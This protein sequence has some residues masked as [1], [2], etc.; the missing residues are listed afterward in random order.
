[1]ARRFKMVD[2]EKALDQTVTIRDVLPPD[3]LARFIARVVLLLDLSAIYAQYAP[4]GG[5]AYAPELLLGLLFY[6]YATGVFSSRKIEKATYESIPFRFLAG[7]WHPDHD[8]IA[9][10]RKTF[11]PEITNLF[12]QVL[13]IAHELGV[14]KLGTIS[15]DGS[16]VHADASKSHAV[17]YGRLLQM[18]RRLSAEVEELIALGETVEREG[19]PEGMDLEF[20]IALREERLLNLG[21][22]KAVLEARAEERHE[23]E[24]AEYEAKLRAREEK[25]KRTGRKPG[26]RPP[27]PPKAGPRAKDQYNFTDPDSRIMKNSNNK[28]FD[29]HY[30]VQVAVEQECRL[31]VGNTLSNH[32]SDRE[33]AI[34]TLDAIPAQIGKPKAAA[35]DNGYW[36]PTNVEELLERSIEP[37]IATGRDSHNQSWRERFAQ[38]SE[39]PAEDVSLIVKMA[40]KL[41][42]DIG[43]RIYGLRKS[44]VEPVIGIIKE[45]LGFRQF[46]LRG[47]LAA[48]GEWC[49]VCLAY[50]LKRLHI[51]MAG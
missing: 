15:V 50:N 13:V 18:E 10:F 8:T 11:L 51:L 23:A 20:E 29:Q 1:M 36:S 17:S 33:E 49:L 6:G 34:P 16:K 12:A 44:T 39:P 28:G 38:Q 30:N 27:Q 45:T 3:H 31:I 48:A 21:Q 22:A 25:A 19:L 5:E 9:N 4:V 41:R 43:K 40:Y 26:G 2:Y 37:F 7:G 14:L 35:L 46:S 42:T 24:K 32:A 47:L